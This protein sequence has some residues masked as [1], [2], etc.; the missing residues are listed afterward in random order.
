LAVRVSERSDRRVE[1]LAWDEHLAGPLA[2]ALGSPDHWSV[3]QGRDA[4]AAWRDGER[5]GRCVVVCVD[6][7]VAGAAGAFHPTLHSHREWAYVEVAPRWRRQGLGTF[8]LDR[9]R[10]VLPGDHLP[11]RGKVIAGAASQAF[12][13]AVGA[14]RMLQRSR[15]VT[16]ARS[17]LATS[18][19]AGFDV[20]AEPAAHAGDEAVE[21]WRRFYVDGHRWDPVG[22][23]GH[24]RARELFFGGD[25][26]A[27]TVRSDGEPVGIALVGP[28]ADR[29]AVVGGPIDSD[30]PLGEAVARALL[31]AVADRWAAPL[32]EVELDDWMTP[33]VA[34]IEALPHQVDETVHIVS[35]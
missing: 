13:T 7:E 30:D 17:D 23:L 32:V 18:V 26:D 6:G 10:S 27:L 14:R 25:G 28:A 22:E 2:D 8:G 20:R 5:W 31:G 34:T 1:A 29:T 4:F 15:T 24:D 35:E 19:P 12:A 33:M 3:R 16:L 21:A 9:L 11:L